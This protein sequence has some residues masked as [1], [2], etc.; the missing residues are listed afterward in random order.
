MTSLASILG[1]VPLA[2]STGAGSASRHAV[3]T[4]VIGGML[5]ATFLAT[6][7]VPMFFRLVTRDRR[8]RAGGEVRGGVAAA[9][10]PR[11]T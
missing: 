9:A 4:G 3:G 5:A 6:F 2:I 7:L 10:A 1:V 8:E 11:E